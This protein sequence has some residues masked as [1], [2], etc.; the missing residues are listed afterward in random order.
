M[1]QCWHGNPDERPTFSQLQIKI[2]AVLSSMADYLEFS[3]IVPC[4]EMDE[5]C[6]HIIHS[7]RFVQMA[8]L[9]G[10]LQGGCMACE[11]QPSCTIT[12]KSV[13]ELTN[14][15]LQSSIATNIN[16]DEWSR[17]YGLAVA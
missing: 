1:Y 8:D 12:F 7:N 13:I 3:E 2:S 9:K 17:Y 4:D 14:C 5:V 16:F 11:V 6:K 10:E 15:C